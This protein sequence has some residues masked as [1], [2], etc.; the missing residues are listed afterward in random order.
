MENVLEFKNVS[1]Y[2]GQKKALDD[3]S[4]VLTPGIYGL[5]GANGAGKSTLLNLLTDSIKRTS[6]EI[7]FN[8]REIL[9][10]GAEFREK[11]GYMPQKQGMYE[12]YSGERFLYYMATLKG[13]NK[14]QA[15]LQISEY[16]ELV[17]LEKDAHRKLGGYS[18]GMKQRLMFC[19]A[20]LGNPEILILDEPTAGLDPEERI[21]IRNYISEM[22]KDKIV[23]LAT[24]VVS[25]IECI[26]SEI[27]FLKEGKLLAKDTPEELIKYVDDKLFSIK[28]GRDELKSLIEKYP[29][30]TV[31]QRKEGLVYTVVRE[32]CPE[33]FEKSSNVP[34]LED[35]YLY[36]F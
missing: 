7:T 32:Q 29:K 3:F 6:G 20:L 2:Y 33:G 16:L 34:N 28:C 8:R 1:K 22:A 30:G 19:C 5:L 10:M 14:K 15:K 4:V 23:I 24:H 18:G 11:L 9:K 26:S 31:Q 36:W 13:V 35:V 17:G 12:H 27:M 25:D 21:K